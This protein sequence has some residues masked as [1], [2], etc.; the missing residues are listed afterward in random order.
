MICFSL[1]SVVNPLTQIYWQ[2]FHQTFSLAMQIFV[3]FTFSS[4][5]HTFVFHLKF[6]FQRI[7]CFPCSIIL[8]SQTFDWYVFISF[9]LYT[10]QTFPWNLDS[11]SISHFDL[12]DLVPKNV[13]VFLSRSFFLFS[14]QFNRN[15]RSNGLVAF[16]QSQVVLDD[17]NVVMTLFV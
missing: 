7:H 11:N 15:L 14:C 5:F 13:F 6:L 9:H 3:H 4:C 12:D 8:W 17:P 10:F 1:H 2:H 16:H